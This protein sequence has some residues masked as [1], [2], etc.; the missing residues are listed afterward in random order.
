M[1]TNYKENTNS[2]P[3]DKFV[4]RLSGKQLS[5]GDIFICGHIGPSMNPT[6]NAQDLLEIE[7]YHNKYPQ[8]GDVILFQP[9]G[10]DHYVV[11][12]IHYMSSDGI[13]TRGDNNCNIDPGLLKTEDIYGRVIARQQGNSCRKIAHGFLGNWVGRYCHARRLLLNQA[14]KYLGPVYR[15]LCSSG[16]LHWLVP[17]R[18]KPQVAAFRSDAN[19]S[20][21]ILLGSRIIGSYDE[22]LLQWQIR[23]PYRLFVDESTLPKPQ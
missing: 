4:S 5:S 23:R 20:Y 7:P 6:L 16:F 17:V 11:H 12:R 15:S 19:E 1:K 3:V 8:V 9:P 18:F 10:H 22:S 13:Q 2:F 14:V 21:K